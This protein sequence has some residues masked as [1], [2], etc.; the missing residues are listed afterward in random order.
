MM[1]TGQSIMKTSGQRFRSLFAGILLLSGL[2]ILV[3]KF[4]ELEY[5]V[6]RLSRVEPAWLIVALLLQSATYV[7]VSSVW[8]LAL[9][10]SDLHLS[11]S[12][13]IP[14]GIA[15]LFSDQALPSVGMSGTA[16]FFTAMNRRGVANDQCMAI[17]LLSLVAYYGAYLL[18]A[19]VTML[20]LCFYN[21]L[22][23]WTVL[24]VM[25]FSF[26]AVGVPTGILW[27]RRLGD[28]KLPQF[29]RRFPGVENLMQSIA[30]APRDLLRNRSL[31][32]SS[33]LLH[34]S[35][36]VLDAATLWVMLHVLGIQASYFA[37]F[38]SF[39]LA[40]MVA[41]IGPIPLG[42]G[43][44]EVTCVSMLRVMGVS[45]EAALTATL[46]L[47]GFTLWLPMLPGMWLARRALR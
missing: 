4:G 16:F 23:A 47:R 15:K 44:F 17:L 10:S 41:T 13:L 27:L 40:S 1:L 22:H 19:L 21:E 14:L 29:M 28:Q 30:N 20:L 18:V 46:L 11:L 9:R 39:V 26:I 45:I 5:F 7:S 8:Y 38:P 6:Q 25:V 31:I 36:F 42:L 12:S 37:V 32:L 2:I 24:V 43:T 35:V 34:G 33:T 3:T